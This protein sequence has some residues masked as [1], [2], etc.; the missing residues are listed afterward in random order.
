MSRYWRGYLHLLDKYPLTTKSLS[1]GVLMGTGDILAQRIDFHFKQQSLNKDNNNT[2]DDNRFKIDYQRV[3]TMTSVG[4]LFSGPVLHYWYTSLDK[5][6]VGSGKTVYIKK[7]LLDQGVFAPIVISCFMG[8]MNTIHGKSLADT[9]QK[10][11]NDLFYAMKANWMLWPAAQLIN[12]SL[13]PPNL[14]VLYTS[15]VSIFWN[16]FLSHLGHKE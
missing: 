11:K 8:I 7:M 4:V 16:I 12:F 14:R 10:I 5:I 9:E 1:T 2:N 3:L 15:V 13:V 6:V